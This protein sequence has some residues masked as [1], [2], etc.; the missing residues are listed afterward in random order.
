MAYLNRAHCDRQCSPYSFSRFVVAMPD[1]NE[2][3]VSKGDYRIMVGGWTCPCDPN[4][5]RGHNVGLI[6]KCSGT[7]PN[8]VRQMPE[9]R[10]YA[11]QHDKFLGWQPYDVHFPI[12]HAH[13]KR[14]LADLF[15]GIRYAW[16]AGKA[17]F[18]H[19]NT[20]FLRSPGAAC[21]FLGYATRTPAIA[22]VRHLS[23]A[24]DIAPIFYEIVERM[25]PGLEANRWTPQRWKDYVMFCRLHD[26]EARIEQWEWNT[27]LGGRMLPRTPRTLVALQNR[28]DEQAAEPTPVEALTPIT[29]GSDRGETARADMVVNLE[30]DPAPI[31]YPPNHF[32]SPARVAS[33]PTPPTSQF[34]GSSN[35]LWETVDNRR[36]Y[37]AGLAPTAQARAAAPPPAASILA[38][39]RP[40]TPP[41]S[42]RLKAT[43]PQS[44]PT[45][46]SGLATPINH[47]NCVSD[48][49]QVKQSPVHQ[50]RQ[51]PQSGPPVAKGPSGA[52]SWIGLLKPKGP[53]PNPKT[54][55][56]FAGQNLLAAAVSAPHF[57]ESGSA[58]TDALVGNITGDFITTGDDTISLLSDRYNQGMQKTGLSTL[59]KVE[60]PPPVAGLSTLIQP[61]YTG[62]AESTSEMVSIHE[63]FID[64]EDEQVPDSVKR[65]WWNS[66]PNKIRDIPNSALTG[67]MQGF[68]RFNHDASLNSGKSQWSYNDLGFHP[69]HS[70]M[71]SICAQWRS[72]PRNHPSYW[73]WSPEE[74]T[75][76]VVSL[77]NEAVHH[78]LS[79]YGDCT[80]R[81]HS[82]RPTNNTPLML[83]AKAACKVVNRHTQIELLE[84]LVKK[85]GGINS[86]DSTGNN[87]VMLAAGH[88]NENIFQWFYE[89][90]PFLK[91]EFRFDWNHKNDDG[92]NV[93]AVVDKKNAGGRVQNWCKDLAKR[94]F[95]DKDTGG[96]S[97]A[98]KRWRP[99]SGR[100]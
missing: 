53:P 6:V 3:G 72:F 32:Y 48:D 50:A 31:W 20:G 1:G 47:G 7:I 42:P 38:P 17:V 55:A 22:W 69:M 28:F 61:V 24:R 44:P 26:V 84:T 34:T 12:M 64:E 66:N 13:Y 15:G 92:R 93:L 43:P 40:A 59:P 51:L 29:V 58:P 5:I 97:S 27:A 94:G 35:P 62:I 75:R 98:N 45:I 100:T 91:E 30:P 71:E 2:L 95:V 99:S 65:Q 56:K 9:A 39:P 36:Q 67:R 70:L 10:D 73:N 89:H 68:L 46:Q 90:A 52:K 11:R 49:H 63:P 74:R 82:D 57:G 23:E 78:T 14:S 19:C 4:C 33:S 37:R 85:G 25:R 8:E 41:Q 77:V 87:A 83:Y 86:V 16:N 60:G 21:L 54:T 96:S 76:F 79:E 88:D 81:T 18:F 80:C